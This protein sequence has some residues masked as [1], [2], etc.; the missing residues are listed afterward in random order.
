L[1]PGFEPWAPGRPAALPGLPAVIGHR[2]AMRHAPENTLASIRK[3]HEL[4]ARWVEFDVKLSRDGVPI[5]MHDPT[6]ERTTDGR[7]RVAAQDHAALAALDAGSRFAAAFAGEPIPTL[8]QTLELLLALEMGANLELKPC[9]G[10]AVETAELVAAELAAHWPATAP[11]ILISSFEPDALRA[12]RRA[13]PERPRGLLLARL[14]PDW[15]ARMTEL[16]CTTLH[17]G[18]R[19][20]DVAGW[21]ALRRAAVPVVVYTVNDALRAN[22]L[23]AAGAR[24][25]ITDAPERILPVAPAQ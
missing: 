12:V 16:A 18:H 10:R 5:L 4:G 13:A 22:Q 2:G 9:P 11:P 14:R 21:A 17:L 8:R 23:F 24:A 1:T 3:A 6:L 19:G 20:V 15:A 7:G 25:I